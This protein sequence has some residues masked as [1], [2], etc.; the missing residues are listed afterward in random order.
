MVEALDRCSKI[1]KS[2]SMVG[3]IKNKICDAQCS[4]KS[5]LQLKAKLNKDL[6]D[7][8]RLPVGPREKII[9]KLNKVNARYDKHLV[10][11][12]ARL[13]KYMANH[14]Q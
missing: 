6:S 4:I 10:T 13:A 14:N 3:A 9:A 7:A 12:R 11:E 1:C 2:G 5:L 8:R